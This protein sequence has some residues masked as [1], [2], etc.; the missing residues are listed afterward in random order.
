MCGSGV[1]VCWCVHMLFVSV[2]PEPDLSWVLTDTVLIHTASWRR[3][4]PGH[5]KSASCRRL[6]YYQLTAKTSVS[7]SPATETSV[8]G[9]CTSLHC[10][11]SCQRCDAFE[12]LQLCWA[13]VCLQGRQLYTVNSTSQHLTLLVNHKC[14]GSLLIA[15]LFRPL[16][17]CITTYTCK[18]LIIVILL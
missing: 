14:E 8:M 11:H 12:V 2:N 18:S 1:C 10:R 7:V 15:T 5:P 9:Q 4:Q 13:E 17:N 3:Q 16:W 6:P